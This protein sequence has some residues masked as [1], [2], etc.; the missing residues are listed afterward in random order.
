MNSSFMTWAVVAGAAALVILL[1]LGSPIGETADAALDEAATEVAADDRTVEA[2]E[3]AT[4][5]Y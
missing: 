1:M 4:T 2:T 5:S 3:V